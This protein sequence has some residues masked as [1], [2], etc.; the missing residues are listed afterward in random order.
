MGKTY[1]KQCKKC[2]NDRKWCSRTCLKSY[3]KNNF[4]NWT[5]GNEEIDDFIREMQL[6]L[7]DKNDV[8]FEWVPHDQLK[9]LKKI[10][11][12]GFATVYSAIWEHGPLH[13]DGKKNDPNYFDGQWKRVA[14]EN[15]ALKC[16]DN[17]KNISKKFLNEVRAY[18][19]ARRGTKVLSVY[20]ISQNPNTKE[21]I[22]ILE[23]ADLGDLSYRI[24]KNKNFDWS[25]KLNKLMYIINGLKEIHQKKMVHRDFHTGNILFKTGKNIGLD[26]RISDM[27]LSGK[28]GNIDNEICGVMPYIAPEVL[29]GNPYTQAADIYSFGMIMYFIATLRQPFQNCAHDIYLALDICEENK[30]PEINKLEAPECYIDL[31]KRCWDPD[32]NNRPDTNKICKLIEL[33]HRSYTTKYRKYAEIKQQFEEAEKYRIS[34]LLIKSQKENS[35]VTHPQAIYTSRLFNISVISEGLGMAI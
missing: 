21:Y 7:N 18:S 1:K 4:S 28:V 26:I 35:T 34:N 3:L 31:M 19:K 17:C 15:V 23:Y 11:K 9:N 16:L 10:G 20:G 13:C 12:G 6:K 32:P 30:R 25:K 33:F 24:N 27:G 29:R 5:S 2:F 14:R 22:M 8:V